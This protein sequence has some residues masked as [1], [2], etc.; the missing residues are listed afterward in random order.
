MTRQSLKL[1]RRNILGLAIDEDGI[2]CAQISASG[3]PVVRRLGR[4]AFTEQAS[5]KTPDALAAALRA[6]L[7]QHHMTASAAVIGLPARWL[8]AQQHE[9]PPAD[10]AAAVAMLRLRA[11]RMAVQDSHAMVFDF[12][13][14]TDRSKPSRVLVLGML[15]SRLD[16]V[17][18]LCDKAGLTP[19]AAM[20]TVLAVSRVFGSEEQP[21]VVI[22]S[23]TADIAWEAPS[24]ARL[25]RHVAAIGGGR[26]SAV[27]LAGELRRTLVLNPALGPAPSGIRVWQDP[28]GAQEDLNLL[29]ERSGLAAERIDARHLRQTTI[30]PTAL[31]GDADRLEADAFLPAIALAMTGAA[32]GAPPVDFLH[33]RLAP[34]VQQRFNRRTVQAIAAAVAVVL[35]LVVFYIHVQNRE[36]EAI[37]LESRLSEMADELRAAQTRLDRFSYGRRYYTDRSRVLDC[38]SHISAAFGTDSSIWTTRFQLYDGRRG[39]LLGRA[40]DQRTVLSVRDRLA[41]NPVF[42]NVSLTEMRTATGASGGITFSM[43]FDFV[44]GEQAR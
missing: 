7:K 22:S 15:Q 21:T 38:L 37:A 23:R 40:T 19:L 24:G 5:L 39:Q 30:S 9:V 1:L 10:P 29:Q 26:T 2:S 12:V 44:G 4:L 34:P 32:D 31:N 17:A 43:T 27:S 41:Q 36:A 42:E 3:G 16:E 33:S 28:T 6:F 8:I 11:E 20:P 25:L 35:G 13:G 18:A 14:Q